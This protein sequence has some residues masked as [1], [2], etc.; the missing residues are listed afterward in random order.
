MTAARFVANV[1][2][3][4]VLINKTYDFDDHLAII[5]DIIK[6]VGTDP[7]RIDPYL[8][9]LTA[10]GADKERVDKYRSMLWM[11]FRVG[12]PAQSHSPM[13]ALD[14]YKA[15]YGKTIQ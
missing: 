2:E 4:A 7:S 8:S 1:N 6:V 3:V 15:H 5:G 13:T 9:S 12:Q 14:Q 10:C 11:M